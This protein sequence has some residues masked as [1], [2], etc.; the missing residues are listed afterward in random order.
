MGD[1]VVET[2]RLILRKPQDGDLDLHLKYLN[3]AA[4]MAHLGGVQEPHVIEA[5]LAR[6]EASFAREGFG[7]MMT[8]EKESGELVGH[9]GLKRVD[10]SLASNQGDME[11][12]W[13]IRE[14]RWRRGY[15]Y[16]AALACRDIA[17]SAHDAPL[18]VALTDARNIGSWRIMEKLGMRRREDLDFSDPA[19]PSADN[20][21]IQY[22]IDRAAWKGERG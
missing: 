17:F 19:F 5:K 7:F 10:N 9:C 2:Q 20:P 15:A 13:L 6:A 18:L 4:V 11:I 21:T 22:S 8:V 16:E 1:P 3:T 14:D 12:G